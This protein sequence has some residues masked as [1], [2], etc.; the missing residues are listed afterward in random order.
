MEEIPGGGSNVMEP[1]KPLPR[2][3]VEPI[4]YLADRMASADKEIAP[5]ERHIIDDLAQA[6]N[7]KGFRDE[8]WFRTL[9][10]EA[11]CKALDIEIAKRG[12]LVVLALVLKA[13]SARKPEEHQLFTRIRTKL[14]APPVTVPLELDSHKKLALKYIS[15]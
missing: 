2:K 7:R 9:T 11:A 14:E 8:R 4:L 6:A 13:D 5:K 15:G 12:A 10:E 3:Y 1:S